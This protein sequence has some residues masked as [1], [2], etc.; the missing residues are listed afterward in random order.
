MIYKTNNWLRTM[1]M[2][3]I[4]FLFT[5]ST[6][7]GQPNVVNKYGLY[8]VK[9]VKLL[10]HEIV[11]DPNKQMTNLRKAIPALI[12]DLK[13]ATSQNFMH[14]KLYPFLHTT[15]LRLPAVIALKEVIS[16]LKSQNITIK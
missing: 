13:Y 7:Y 6:I 15:F 3:P 14:R 11:T 2:F 1:V 8:V 10:H 12:L 9:D 16:A 5:V 4:I